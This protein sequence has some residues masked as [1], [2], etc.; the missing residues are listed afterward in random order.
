MGQIVGPASGPPAPLPSYTPRA[1]E[2]TP[3]SKPLPEFRPLDTKLEVLRRDASGKVIMPALPP[4]Y[5]VFESFARSLGAEE[6]NFRKRWALWLDERAVFQETLL[7]EEVTT[8]LTLRQSLAE[9]ASTPD[10]R[11][12]QELA[13][14]TRTVMAVPPMITDMTDAGRFGEAP[15]TA[16]RAAV[17]ELRT[18][19]NAV[20]VGSMEPSERAKRNLEASRLAITLNTME[21]MMMLDRLLSRSV[22]RWSEVRPQLGLSPEQ[23]QKLKPMEAEIASA[24]DAAARADLGARIATELSGQQKTLMLTI[25]RTVPV[26]TDVATEPARDR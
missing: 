17:S 26:P 1:V 10:I 16:L 9:L 15:A 11:R 23:E 7:I 20:A 12:L 3:P 5:E 13:A 19:M 21:S 8:A 24:K 4:D 2:P 18:A 25:V 22:E 6:A 14:L